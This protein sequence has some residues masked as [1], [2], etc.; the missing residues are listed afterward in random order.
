[1][2]GLFLVSSLIEFLFPVLSPQKLGFGV[3]LPGEHHPVGS[4]LEQ[5]LDEVAVVAPADVG[6]ED[7]LV[8]KGAEVVAMRQQS[9]VGE[10]LQLLGG[11]SS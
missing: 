10:H 6:A 1:M 4:G 2:S 3:A 11:D 5:L 7:S 9:V 8:L